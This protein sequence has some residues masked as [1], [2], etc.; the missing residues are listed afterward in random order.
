MHSQLPRFLVFFFLLG[1]GTQQPRRGHPRN[2]YQRFG[3][4]CSYYHWP[5][6]LPYPSLNFH[7]GS[8]SAIF[9]LIAQQ[10]STL[11]CCGL[12]T[13]QDIF[14]ILH[15]VCSD[16]LTMSPPSLEQMD[17]RVF[18]SPLAVLEHPLKQTKNLS[19]MVNNSDADR[20]ILFKFGIDWPH[21]ASSTIHLQ[22]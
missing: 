17:P 8:K 12:A 16:D 9:D 7:R 20:P 11:S 14:T 22:G 21:D 6:D 5:R 15:F 4:R 1:H 3:H 19:L 13:E 10:R 2:V 18:K